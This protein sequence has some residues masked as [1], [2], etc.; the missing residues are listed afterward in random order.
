M[1]EGIAYLREETITLDAALN[2]VSTYKDRQ[3]FVKPRS[4]YSSEFY[5]A[6]KS[7]LQPTV[8]LVLASAADYQ[9]E[10]VCLYNG[11]EYTVIR[12]YQ[13]PERDTIELTLE[14]RTQNGG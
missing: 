13:R 14:E 1:Y 2:Q 11:K 6:A 7:G 10:K 9:S 4:V 12:A 3:V 5:E 8:V